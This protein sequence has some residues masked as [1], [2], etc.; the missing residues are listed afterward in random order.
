MHRRVGG[1]FETLRLSLSSLNGGFLKP[2]MLREFPDPAAW[3][4]PKDFGFRVLAVIWTWGLRLRRFR[5]LRWFR[6]EFGGV[7]A[8]TFVF[9]G[10]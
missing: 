10:F 4:A 6:G 9:V 1:A 5:V 3:G 8:Q 2:K 7:F